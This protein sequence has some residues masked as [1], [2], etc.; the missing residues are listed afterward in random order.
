MKDM[1]AARTLFEYMLGAASVGLYIRSS[2]FIEY[3][4][5]VSSGCFP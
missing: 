2:L 4:L 5:N 3:P 1:F